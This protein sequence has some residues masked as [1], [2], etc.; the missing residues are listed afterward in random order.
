MRRFTVR[1]LTLASPLL[2]WQLLEL[3]V[4]PIDLVAFRPWEALIVKSVSWSYIGPFYPNM[5]LV[6]ESIGYYDYSNKVP[7]PRRKH[8]EWITDENGLR[9]RPRPTPP[10][11]YEVVLTGDSAIAGAFNDQKDM[12]SEVLERDCG[13]PVY[14]MGQAGGL[15]Y[16]DNDIFIRHPPRFLVRNIE[17]NASA[18]L[19]AISGSYDFFEFRLRPSTVWPKWVLQHYDRFLKQPAREFIRARSMITEIRRWSDHAES[20]RKARRLKEQTA[21]DRAA[22]VRLIASADD[23]RGQMHNLADEPLDTVLIDSERRALAT[24][25]RLRAQGTRLILLFMPWQNHELYAPLIK[26]LRRK[27]VLV[28]DFPPTA[29]WPKGYPD[30]FWQKEDSHWTE[31]AVREVSKRILEQM[32]ASVGRTS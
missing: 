26:S 25:E 14:N 3:F 22:T 13:C 17:L 24:A 2:A 27:G 16:V 12:L 31:E 1:L 28:V 21:H 23:L 30:S 4:L 19:T 29:E 18:Y 6:K 20:Q 8:E 15:P 10:N 32:R 11:G 9:N 5:R 7:N